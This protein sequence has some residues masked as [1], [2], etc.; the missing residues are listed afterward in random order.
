MKKTAVLCALLL[1]LSVHAQMYFSTI[2]SEPSSCRTSG[3]Q[4]G[5]GV[6]YAGV[7]GGQAPITYMWEELA[8]GATSSST[9]WGMRK[10]GYYKITATDANSAV[11]ID[12]VRVDS[13]NPVA[14]FT[15]SGSSLAGG[16]VLYYG[17]APVTVTFDNLSTG[18]PA[19][20][21][22]PQTDTVFQWQFT[23]FSNWQVDY[24]WTQHQFTYDYAGYYGI[25]L[26]VRNKNGCEDTGYI[27]IFLDGPAGIEDEEKSL[28]ISRSDENLS[29]AYTGDFDQKQLVFY[30]LGG[31]MLKKEVFYG[32]N[33]TIS[34]NFGNG[35]FIFKCLDSGT[36]EL[37][38]AG[39]FVF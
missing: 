14:N 31:K 17:V 15:A 19:I 7:D 16:G 18:I 37:I 35:T 28:I 26:F 5:D 3:S 4:L 8:T 1:S 33:A 9:T 34:W 10:P 29:I 12:T 2:G 21:P 22:F 38:T 11:I 25:T 30:N 24:D 6:V 39:K 13:I 27:Q 20:I 32:E 23:Q 36:G